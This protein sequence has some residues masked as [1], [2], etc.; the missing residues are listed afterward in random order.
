[1]VDRWRWA[2]GFVGI[3]A[4]GAVSLVESISRSRPPP[5]PSTASRA[6][7]TP[8]LD[9]MPGGGPDGGW[10]ASL[11]VTATNPSVVYA[12][13]FDG[14]V[15][16]SRDRGLSWA[17]A[18]RGLP[19]D[20]GCEIVAAPTPTPTLYAACGDGL[21]KTTNGGTL[22]IQL[23]LDNPLPPIIAP[24]DGRVLYMP[25][26]DIVRSADG[27]H[28]WEKLAAP[29]GAGCRQLVVHPANPLALFCLGDWI[30]TSRD[31]GAT[32][33]PLSKAPTA[34][35][36]VSALAVSPSHGDTIL[37][38]TTDGRT[39]KTRDGGAT[40]YGSP[41]PGEEVG[42]LQFIGASGDVVY[43]GVGSTIRR[44]L[45]GGGQWEVLPL[46]VGPLDLVDALAVDP[47][48]PST[49]YV[50]TRDGVLATR[51]FGRNWTRRSSGLTRAR[52][53]VA[54]EADTRPLLRATTE[55]A[56]FVSRDEGTTWTIASS[57]DHR[58]QTEAVKTSATPKSSDRST[59]LLPNGEPAFDMVKTKGPARLAY[60][61]TGGLLGWIFNTH[62]LWRS[63]D[64]GVSWQRGAVPGGLSSAVG[65]CCRLMVD[66]QDESTAYAIVGGVGIG[67]TG[68]LVLRSLDAGRTWAEL[69]LPGLSTHLSI[70]GTDPPTLVLQA[71][72]E[73][74]AGGRYALYV[75]TDRGETWRVS[76]GLPATVAVNSMVSDPRRPARLFAGTDGRGVFRSLD[77]GATWQPAG[78]TP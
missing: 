71:L 54:I 8:V 27:G 53:S 18:D 4:I 29:T 32:W 45:D 17:P 2:V 50:G 25:F 38:G 60:A 10:I 58:R 34:D 26:G 67:R 31:G 48:E 65:D 77:A 70:A 35:I 30:T 15:F 23:D 41:S 69:P 62:A 63:E 44:S 73:G 64:D 20:I 61:S 3:L 5:T 66:P 40:W 51:D 72:D 59:T 28:R 14:G 16:V 11:A 68:D 9:H 46:E 75:S 78:R 39:F 33:S 24:S 36:E 52:V 43:A 42:W 21:F 37:V 19:A 22:W 57:G 13:A 55:H 12:A 47:A 7:D 1:M 74:A 49:V 76:A 6:N 56:T